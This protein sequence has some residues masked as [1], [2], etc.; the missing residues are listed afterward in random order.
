MDWWTGVRAAME[1]FLDTHGVLASFVFIL[2]EEAGILVP[3]PGDFLM[4]VA[5]VHAR[6]GGPPLWQ[7]LAAMEAAPS[8]LP[9]RVRGAGVA[10]P[11]GSR[12]EHDTYAQP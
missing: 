4:L 2:I 1:T 10:A 9:A 6:Q 11:A 7:F 5:G 3:V 8:G 12:E